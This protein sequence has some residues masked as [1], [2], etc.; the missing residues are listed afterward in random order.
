VSTGVLIRV[1]YLSVG[2][3]YYAALTFSH[4]GKIFNLSRAD[5]QHL[6]VPG[7]T[8]L[9][10]NANS[11]TSIA[12]CVTTILV[13]K[14]HLVKPTTFGNSTDRFVK[15]ISGY[16]DRY[17]WNREEAALHMIYREKDYGLR[18][19]GNCLQFSTLPS[20]PSAGERCSRTSVILKLTPYCNLDGGGT[21]KGYVQ[22]GR[23]SKT[24]A[25]L[26]GKDRR[27]LL[28]SRAGMKHDDALGKG[29]RALN[30]SSK[31]TM[32]RFFN[33]I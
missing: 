29:D 9:C 4:S 26:D 33:L 6:T 11:S 17:E 18:V 32:F 25:S 19:F 30:C 10:I 28:R 31:G 13:E 21:L 23:S 14:C 12:L 2:R 7:D 15:S 1:T 24:V 22:S 16:P 20:A 27:S 8:L 3:L 5:P